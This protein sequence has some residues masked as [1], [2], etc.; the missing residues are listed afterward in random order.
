[1]T[2]AEAV[3]SVLLAWPPFGAEPVHE[4]DIDRQIRLTQAAIVVTEAAEA[5]PGRWPSVRVAA[6]LLA[7]GHGESR[8]ARYVGVGLCHTGPKGARCG[9]DRRGRMRART[10]WQ[11]EKP[12]C[13]EL[14]QHEPGSFIEILSAARCASRLFVG[15]YYRCGDDLRGAFAGY[16][17]GGGCGW[18]PAAR[19]A[20]RMRRIESRLRQLLRSAPS[21]TQQPISSTHVDMLPEQSE[22]PGA[23]GPRLLRVLAL[24]Y[25][26]AGMPLRGGH[27][28]AWVHGPFDGAGGRV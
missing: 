6:A 19:R 5:R 17:K 21:V 2:L 9:L 28:I 4:T 15:A 23:I 18:A 13:R 25:D 14:W 27:A 10:Y 20:R 12:A 22:Q 1:M 24:D 7:L 16:A 3:L 8:F 26:A 11:I